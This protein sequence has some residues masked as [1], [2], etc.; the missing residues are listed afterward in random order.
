[1]DFARSGG[2]Y[3]ARPLTQ[4]TSSSMNNALGAWVSRSAGA[5][6]P[7]VKLR[8]GGLPPPTSVVSRRRRTLV[9]VLFKWRFA[10]RRPFDVLADSWR[11]SFGRPPSVSRFSQSDVMRKRESGGAEIAAW[12]NGVY[13]CAGLAAIVAMVFAAGG[14]DS[15]GAAGN[16]AHWA[17]TVTIDGQPIPQDASASILFKPT[18]SGQAKSVSAQILQGKYDSPETPKG[19][20]KAFFSISRPTGRMIREGQGNPYPEIL[21]IVSSE[22]GSGMELDVSEDDMNRDFDLKSQ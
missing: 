6:G 11:S 14:C 22:Y 10:G 2:T 13:R 3:S 18:Q 19:H 5:P 12:L 15:R 8:E 9:L 7:T 20:V 1:V 21:S 17:G 16:T 4:F